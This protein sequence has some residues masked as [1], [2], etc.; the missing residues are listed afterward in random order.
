MKNDFSETLQPIYFGASPFSK[1]LKN[2]KKKVAA[3][4][5]KLPKRGPAVKIDQGKISVEVPG[6]LPAKATAKKFP[7]VPVVLA[8]AGVLALMVF[9]KKGKKPQ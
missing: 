6:K 1:A 5:A 3:V 4:R 8:G 2:I 9:K 7:V